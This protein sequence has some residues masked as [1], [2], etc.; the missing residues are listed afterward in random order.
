MGRVNRQNSLRFA[1][2]MGLIPCLFRFFFV[3]F[4]HSKYEV[5]FLKIR[6]FILNFEQMRRLN[7]IM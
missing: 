1:Y 7:E 2:F 3:E 5:T 6:K 4:C